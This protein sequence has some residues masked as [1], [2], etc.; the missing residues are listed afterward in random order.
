[1]T[2][3]LEI[4][5]LPQEVQRQIVDTLPPELNVGSKDGSIKIDAKQVKSI[6]LDLIVSP[7]I[8]RNTDTLRSALMSVVREIVDKGKMD[9]TV[10][11]EIYITL[12]LNSPLSSRK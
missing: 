3:T 7:S 8:F 4:P 2:T 11:E 5:S 12:T 6:V 10:R 1:M 9:T